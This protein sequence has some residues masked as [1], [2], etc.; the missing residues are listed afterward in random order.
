M[1]TPLLSCHAVDALYGGVRAVSSADLAVNQGQ[2]TCLIGGNGAGKSTLLDV[3]TGTHRAA[4]GRVL[5]GDIDITQW[6][7]RDRVRA[8]IVRLFQYAGGFHGLTM[9]ESV[10]VALPRTDLR[11]FDLPGQ[12][13]ARRRE[14]D[15][16]LASVGFAAGHDRI[17]GRLSFGQQR[18]VAIAAMLA[19]EARILLVDEPTAGLDPRSVDEVRELLTELRRSGRTILLVEHS[20][21]FVRDIADVVVLMDGGATLKV[22]TPASVLEDPDVQ[23]RLLGGRVVA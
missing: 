14:A 11:P 1:A 10:E 5:L 21:R 3:L 20:L 15:A 12:G 4:A 13:F 17:V 6:S 18:R 2:I 22:L 9:R 7:V 19:A 23:L 16:I 8:G